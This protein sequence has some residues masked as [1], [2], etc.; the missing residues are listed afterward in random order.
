M[1]AVLIYINGDE[2]SVGEM[3][4]YDHIKAVYKD[5]NVTCRSYYSMP[6][7]F[8]FDTAPMWAMRSADGR[9]V[10]FLKKKTPLQD[11]KKWIA[12][13][14]KEEQDGEEL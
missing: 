14:M 13:W 5:W 8:R 3:F 1:Q 4:K 2:S 9:W 11:L 6:I 7:D 10:A 12:M